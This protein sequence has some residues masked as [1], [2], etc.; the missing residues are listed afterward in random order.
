MTGSTS[1][2]SSELPASDYLEGLDEIEGLRAAAEGLLAGEVSAPM[3]ASAIEFILEGLHLSN[4]LNKSETRDGARY[5][6][7]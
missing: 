4:H 3:L 2:V 7:A 1:E 6:T 5:G